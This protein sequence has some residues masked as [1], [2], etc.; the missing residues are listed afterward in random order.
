MKSYA[1]NAN[2]LADSILSLLF[3]PDLCEKV[4]KNAK[5]KV[6][7]EYNWTKIT[8]ETHFT[9]EKAIAETMADRQAKQIAQEEAKQ[10][11]KRT[12]EI[13]NL[14]S[15]KKARQAFAAQ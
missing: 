9:Y 14:L 7:A 8:D 10:D 3:N 6:K 4:T 5:E 1:G 13:A 15:F 12:N 2:S 11:I